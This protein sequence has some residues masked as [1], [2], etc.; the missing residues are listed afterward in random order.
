M[1]RQL[2][3]LSIALREGLRFES[4]YAG[5]HHQALLTH[6]QCVIAKDAHA[7]IFLWGDEESGKSHLLEASC[8]LAYEEGLRAG[9]YPLRQM[10]EHGPA[11]FS[12]SENYDLICLDDLD[13]VLKNEQWER[14]IFNMINLARANRQRLIISAVVKPRDIVCDLPDLTSR[15]PWG[16]SYQLIELSDAEKAEAIKLRAKQRGFV[17]SDA[18]I[19]Y[20]YNH[21]PRNFNAL[22]TILDRLDQASLSDQRKVTVPFVK[23]VLEDN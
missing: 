23:Q 22:I 2:P 5:E 15:L 3:L 17:L 13:V 1:T 6:L 14:A 11:V 20:I 12:G 7:Q 21:C 4:F 16:T 19:D 9:Y 18:V 10:L 8:L